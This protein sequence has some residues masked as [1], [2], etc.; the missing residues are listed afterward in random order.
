M[1][2]LRLSLVSCSNLLVGIVSRAAGVTIDTLVVLLTWYKT[3]GIKRESRQLGIN[4]PYVTLLLR[5]GEFL[6]FVS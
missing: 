6:N 3:Y 1:S 5:D 4:T 2:L